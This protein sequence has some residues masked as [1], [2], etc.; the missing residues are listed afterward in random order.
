[1]MD[2]SFEISKNPEI[3]FQKEFDF[4]K[5]SVENVKLDSHYDEIDLYDIVEIHIKDYDYSNDNFTRRLEK[6]KT[7]NGFIHLAGGITFEICD[8]KITQIILRK[9][10][11]NRLM[12]Y[13]KKEIVDILGKPHKILKDE[14]LWDNGVDTEIL[15]YKP[16]SV[17]FFIDVQTGKIKEIHIGDLKEKYYK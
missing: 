15:L 10:Y 4:T 7:H 14:N 16:G 13:G 8:Q 17:C 11:L 3:F 12:Q 2:D 6:F 9:R 5:I 1:M